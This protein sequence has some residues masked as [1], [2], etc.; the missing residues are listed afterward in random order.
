MAVIVG[1]TVMGLLGSVG[2]YQLYET[3]LQQLQES[4]KPVQREFIS[5]L[6]N[7]STKQKVALGMTTV[8]ALALTYCLMRGK[9]SLPEPNIPLVVST[10][11][12]EESLVA[13]SDFSERPTPN[14]Q[15]YVARK[16]QSVKGETF[17][18]VGCCFRTT[19]GIWVPAHVL[20]PDYEQMYIIGR[21]QQRAV[22]GGGSEMYTPAIPL[23]PYFDRIN[24]SEQFGAEILSIPLD[25]KDMSQLGLTAAKFTVLGNKQMV[26]IVGPGNKSSMGELTSGAIMGSLRYY[27]STQSGFSGAPYML[28]GRVVGIHLHGGPGGNGGQE[29]MYLNQLYKIALNIVEESS[30]FFDSGAKVMEMAFKKQEEVQVEEQGDY[31]VYRD[32]GGHYHRVQKK[33]YYELRDRYSYQQFD[34]ESEFSDDASY[35]GGDVQEYDRYHKR[36]QY[37][38]ESKRPFLYP[39]LK[40][41]VRVRSTQ[42][43][44]RS[45]KSIEKRIQWLNKSLEKLRSSAN[46]K[47]CSPQ[48]P[49]PKEHSTPSSSSSPA[50]TS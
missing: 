7:I 47:P 17:E 3:A 32:N 43:K 8:G 28:N 1:R 10:Y 11:K 9:K 26:T 18:I 48:T 20:G 22:K 33:T 12:T 31:M 27:G 24:E 23:G 30:N 13:G 42:Q 39:A 46:P 41:S 29:V 16:V 2:A 5:S 37:S 35:Y 21:K 14:C 15:G 44:V 36:G 25:S 19:F 50:V 45:P 34:D 38:E 4:P 6:L 49:V 40:K